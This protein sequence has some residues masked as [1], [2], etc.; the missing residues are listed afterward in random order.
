LNPV[1]QAAIFG[2]VRYYDLFCS[3]WNR[4]NRNIS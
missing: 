2:S 4:N 1:L 3:A